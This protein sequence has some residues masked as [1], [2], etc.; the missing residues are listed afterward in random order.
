[1]IDNFSLNMKRR[2]KS[3]EAILDTTFELLKEIGFQNLTIE[4]IAKRAKVG[5]TTIYRWWGSKGALAVE[6]F[7]KKVEPSIYF[8]ESGSAANDISQ[9]MKKL[10]D[11][12]GSEEGR[13]IREILA[14][15]QFDNETLLIFKDGFLKPRRLAAKDI[16]QRGIQNGEFKES[17]E[18]DLI[19]DML[20]GPIYYRL[21]TG[22]IPNDP[23]FLQALENIVLKGLII[24]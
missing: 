7:L 24:D 4:G 15:A 18:F 9:Q 17:I 2:S 20:Y 21:I 6:A 16:L 13:I 1:M 23:I 11:I 5:K 14:T 3:N 22:D 10:A 8:E 12:F 19:L